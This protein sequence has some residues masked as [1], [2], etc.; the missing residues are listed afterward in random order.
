[1][2]TEWTRKLLDA[3]ACGLTAIWTVLATPAPSS[4]CEEPE[5]YILDGSDCDDENALSNPSMT[6]ICNGI[7]DDCI[8]GIDEPT[9]SDATLWFLDSDLDGFGDPNTPELNCNQ[10]TGFLS[11]N[12]DCDDENAL[13]NPSMTE[14]CNGTDDNCADGVDE[15]TAADATLWYLDNDTDG[16]G[17]PNVSERTCNQPQG[18][19]SDGTDCDDALPYT[20]PG[21]AELDDPLLC[22]E[23][24]DDDGFG[25]VQPIGTTDIGTDCNDGGAAISPELKSV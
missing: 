3:A 9:A 14:V 10:P 4:G 17:N 13:V 20:H 23:D 11:N 12:T 5:G 21:A 18:F 22:L 6:E 8:N 7:D 16:F 1:M 2:S 25:S 15:P 24:S 19:V